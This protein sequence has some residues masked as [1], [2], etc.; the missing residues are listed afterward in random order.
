MDDCEID[1]IGQRVR[2][3]GELGTIWYF[4]PLKVAKAGT[5]NWY[6]IE[7]DNAN[8]GKHNGTVEGEYYF[9]PIWHDEDTN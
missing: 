6:G 8:K 1:L 5:D 7:W 9:K 4:G 3:K 2:I